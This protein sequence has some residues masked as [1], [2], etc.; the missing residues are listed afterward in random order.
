MIISCWNQRFMHK[1][2]RRT[3]DVRKDKNVVKS[4]TDNI[5]HAIIRAVYSRQFTGNDEKDEQ[6]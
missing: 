1:S 5:V 3:D 6:L 4:E 2:V